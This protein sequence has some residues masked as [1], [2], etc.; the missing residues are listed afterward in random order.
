MASLHDG[1]EVCY[2]DGSGEGAS[3]RGPGYCEALVL[4]A[5]CS[6][7]LQNTARKALFSKIKDIRHTGFHVI[8]VFILHPNNIQG[9]TIY[10]HNL[11]NGLR[12]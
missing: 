12:H 6:M 3:A 5:Q 2:S 4:S 8:I 7:G 10:K 11:V 9:Q 1:P